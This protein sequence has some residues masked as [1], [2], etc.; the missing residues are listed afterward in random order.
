MFLLGDDRLLVHALLF[1]IST[2][3]HSDRQCILI[4][5]NMMFLLSLLGGQRAL[6]Y[7][8]LYSLYCNK[9]VPLPTR[10]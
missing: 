3:V 7:V 1:L 5:V 4:S 8:M 9:Y 6:R 10:A 2:P